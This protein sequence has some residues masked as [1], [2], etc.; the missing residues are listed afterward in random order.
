VPRAGP[1]VRDNHYGWFD[2]VKVGHYDL[3][4]KGR[5]DLVQWSDAL[6]DLTSQ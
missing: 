6:E 1:I 3:S 2:R 5:E 4:P